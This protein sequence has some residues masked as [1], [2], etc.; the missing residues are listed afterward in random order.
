MGTGAFS[1]AL[2]VLMFIYIIVP[3]KKGQKNPHTLELLNSDHKNGEIE[4][5]L[6]EF[7][8]EKKINGIINNEALLDPFV[9]RWRSRITLV[10]DTMCFVLVLFYGSQKLA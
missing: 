5:L 4:Q 2:L 7:V 8:S 9:Q 6:F 3:G 1:A 10:A